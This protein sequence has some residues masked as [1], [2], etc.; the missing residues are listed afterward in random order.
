MA[1]RS[2]SFDC[3]RRWSNSLSAERKVHVTGNNASHPISAGKRSRLRQKQNEIH[4]EQP[5]SRAGGANALFVTKQSDERREKVITNIFGFH[6]I[7]KSRTERKRNNNNSRNLQVARSSNPSDGITYLFIRVRE[8]KR[9][10][11]DDALELAT[12]THRPAALWRTEA[13]AGAFIVDVVNHGPSNENCNEKVER[14]AA[15]SAPE[16]ERKKWAIQLFPIPFGWKRVFGFNHIW[17]R[18]I[19]VDSNA[20]RAL[21]VTDVSILFARFSC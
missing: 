6:S 4:Y 1:I 17:G 14:M 19:R 9:R 18:H 10:K 11:A 3:R 20:L 8:H 15:E 13:K 2:D 16:G 5:S 12:A 7:G 21:G